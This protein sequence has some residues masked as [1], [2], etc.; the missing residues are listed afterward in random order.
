MPAPRDA[1]KCAGEPLPASAAFDEADV[2]DK[3]LW[4]QALPRLTPA[5][6]AAITKDYDA[7]LETLDAVNEG[8]ARVMKTLKDT[9][10]LADTIVIFTSDN[11]FFFGEHRIPSG[12]GRFYEPGI[13]VPLVIRGPGI[14]HGITQRSLV[15]NVDLAPTILD[16]AGAKPLRPVDGTSM[17]PLLH[18]GRAGRRT[19][20]SCSS[21][22]ASSRPTSACGHLGM[23]TSCST[24]GR[25]SST[26]CTRIPTSSTT[27]LVIP[28]TLQWK[29]IWPPASQ[30][31]STAR[32]RPAAAPEP[33]VRC[34][35][36]MAAR[37][38]AR[39]IRGHCRRVLGP[40]RRGR[41]KKLVVV[42]EIVVRVVR[43]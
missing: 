39:C 19:A 28:H 43:V 32:G 17:V 42:A 16:L 9:H 37:T 36:L 2:S 14:E 24:R 40:R 22:T 6:D 11:G 31:S 10:Q 33:Q 13:R 8:V 35:L 27:S 7:T 5:A 1:G 26:T 38:L 34:K 3:P 41:D 30:S 20:R 18:H 23:R 29:L 25:R 21:P 12:K 4:V 15:A